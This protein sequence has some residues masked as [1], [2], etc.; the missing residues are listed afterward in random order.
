MLYYIDSV[1]RYALPTVTGKTV[2]KLN[3]KFAKQW[4]SA[5]STDEP[6]WDGSFPCK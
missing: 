1:V 3:V 5:V 4:H 6:R 2:V